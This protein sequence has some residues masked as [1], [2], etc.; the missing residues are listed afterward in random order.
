MSTTVQDNPSENRYE[1]FDEDTVA[2]FTAYKLQPGQIAFTHT[3]T[4]PAF[5][6]QGL[7]KRLVAE[8]LDDVRRRGLAVLPFCPYVRGFIARNPD[9]LDLVRE[10]DRPRFELTPDV[11]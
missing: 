7:A 8:A 5:A 9:Y 11:G 4:E 6:G 2:G 10:E 3:E 1:I